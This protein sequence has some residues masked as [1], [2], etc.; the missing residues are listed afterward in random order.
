MKFTMKDMYHDRC[1][2]KLW[3]TSTV[4][5]GFARAERGKIEEDLSCFFWQMEGKKRII[6]SKID[7]WPREIAF[8]LWLSVNALWKYPSTMNSPLNQHLSFSGL[9]QVTHIL[10]KSSW[11]CF[12]FF[13]FSAGRKYG[14][15]AF[16]DHSTSKQAQVSLSSFKQWRQQR[17]NFFKD[18][19][20]TLQE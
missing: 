15:I 1:H 7:N 12:F 5:N 17:C 11:S 19:I 18:L 2:T 4:Q 9:H 20:Q 8:I 13:G 10:V 6:Y 14:L 3:R 16:S